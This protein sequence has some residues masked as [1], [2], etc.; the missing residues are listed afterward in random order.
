MSMLFTSGRARF[1]G[2]GMRL[3]CG[4]LGVLLSGSLLAQPVH[5]ASSALPT[6]VVGD[7]NS[8]DNFG[9]AI[10]VS[11]DYVVI[12]AYGDTAVA[13][14]A[15]FGIA[16]GSAY[17]FER[18]G[19]S[20]V[21]AQK[22]EP[23]SIGED[24]D[25]FG[26]SIAMVDDFLAI[27]APRRSQDGLFE[28]GT[29]FVYGRSSSGYLLRQILSP[30]VTAAELRFGAA[31]ALWQDQMAIGVPGAG[32][33]R[34]DLY[35]RE[36]SGSYV[37]ERSLSPQPGSTAAQFGAALAMADGELLVGAPAADGVGAVYRSIHSVAGWSAASRLALAAT[38]QME[39]G[40]AL[41]IADG[42]ALV[43]A[44]GAAAGEVR[45][46]TQ[47]GGAWTQTAVLSAS[48]GVAGD[49]FG[50]A[51]SVDA[52]RAAIGAVAALFSEGKTYL[53]SRSGNAFTLADALDIADGET[54]NRF[55]TSVA[56]AAGGVLIGADLD[57]VGPNR[58]QGSVRWFQPQ[59]LDYVQ[60]TQLNNG[61]G[62]M[63]DRYGTAV[64]VSGEFALVGA[65]LEDTD[66]G[67]D[68]G[69]AH[70][71][72]RVG[73]QWNYGGQLLAPDGA[74]EDRFGI[75]VDIDGERMAVGAFWDVV[76]SNID[77]G[78]VYIYRR[79][80]A[81]WIFEAK[82]VADDGG[83]GDYFGFALSLDGD[84]LLVGARGASAPASEQGLAYVFVRDG[85]GWSQ[86]ARLELAGI[87]SLAYFGASVA[88]AGDL[89]LV[90]A[91][92]ASIGSVI[93]APGAALVFRRVGGTWPLAATLQAP[94][95]RVN[96]AYGFAVAADSQRLLVGAFQD[97]VFASGA[98][99]VYRA[100]DLSLEGKLV[101]TLAQPGEGLGIAVALAGNTAVLGA[102]GYDLP[103]QFGVG[104]VRIFAHGDQGWLEQQQ[105]FAADAAAGDGFGR[106]VAHD[107]VH[108]VI[109]APG[110]GIDNPLEGTAYVERIDA[111]FADGFED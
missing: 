94:Q 84:R 27:G 22:L 95:P 42:V 28:S 85:T 73:G 104:T 96:A 72:Q 19:D 92:G 61:N 51:L 53:Y 66:A 33:G 67:P 17:V 29:V 64:A 76:G 14:D 3:C 52:G 24:G 43:G 57:R 54:A 65:Y 60:T 74:I 5:L 30:T 87:N 46:L 50:N 39:L 71:F 108:A 55:G 83:E 63:Y 31:I 82:L 44:P 105:W 69:A 62:A 40:A 59:G 4:I 11:G 48:D 25:N 80:G 13:P 81:D 20:W 103:G 41:A 2:W 34:V 8:G 106:A 16:Q 68:A 7:G 12:G 78:S 47:V 1:F 35:Q 9:N 70:W 91:P 15:L 49:R 77:Q 79:V 32:D 45:V 109:G 18:S 26:F 93:E 111:L 88:L 102:P 10:A 98:A 100:V 38:A 6:P 75:A 86:E 97:G 56:L 99:Y 37:F 89:A 90:G 36:A 107:G 21:L 58:G 110:K 23:D 101:A